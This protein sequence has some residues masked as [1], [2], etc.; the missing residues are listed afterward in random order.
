MVLKNFAVFTRK[1]L[2]CSFFSDMKAC[3]FI[4]KRLQHRCFSVNIVK[5]LRAPFWK[6]ICK[7]LLL[8]VAFMYKKEILISFHIKLKTEWQKIIYL[9][10]FSLFSLAERTSNFFILKLWLSQFIC[11]S[12]ESLISKRFFAN[13]ILLWWSHQGG[14]TRPWYFRIH[15]Q[16]T[17]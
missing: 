12:K 15:I 6:N 4:K 2:H 13:Q 3:N 1:Q 11:S 7:P 17:F 8:R 9:I 16:S 5:F 10:F 14:K